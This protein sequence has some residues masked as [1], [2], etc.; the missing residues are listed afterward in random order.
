[1]KLHKE[2]YGVDMGEEWAGKLQSEQRDGGSTQLTVGPQDVAIVF[3]DGGIHL[4]LPEGITVDELMS[5]ET[6]DG[7]FMGWHV[8]AAMVALESMDE[9]LQ[10]TYQQ[11]DVDQTIVK[12]QDQAMKSA[13]ALFVNMAKHGVIDS[14]EA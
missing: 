11:D 8:W 12:V 10:D 5:G 13:V 1:M 7:D 9:A 3:R 14:G 4:V 2:I 6:A